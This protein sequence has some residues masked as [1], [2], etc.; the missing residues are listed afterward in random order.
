MV[1]DIGEQAGKQSS[2]KGGGPREQTQRSHLRKK[3]ED[4]MCDLQHAV[5]WICVLY[6]LYFASHCVKRDFRRLTVLHTRV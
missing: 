1:D 5:A 4:W 3:P 2:Q 6:A